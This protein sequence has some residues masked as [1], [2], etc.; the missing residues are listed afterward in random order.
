MIGWFTIANL[1]YLWCCC[2]HRKDW[3]RTGER[4][5]SGRCMR[6]DR[7]CR[8]CNA[9]APHETFSYHRDL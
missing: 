3:Q 2:F 6:Y 1:A 5:I 7:F 4:F 9:P 8:R